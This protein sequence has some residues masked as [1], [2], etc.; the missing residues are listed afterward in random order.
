[1]SDF[2]LLSFEK[3][4]AS[5]ELLSKA[6]VPCLHLCP[7]QYVPI[8][9][10][11]L[12]PQGAVLVVTS[13][14]SFKFY[15]YPEFWRHRRL[16][17]VGKGTEA[18]AQTLGLEPEFVGDAGGAEVVQAAQLAAPHIFHVGGSDLS[19]PLQVAL[20][21]VT[22]TRMPVYT[23]KENALFT[24]STVTISL[25]AI[26]SPAAAHAIGRHDVFSKAP[27]VCIGHTTAEA[28]TAA[29]LLVVGVAERPRF[30]DLTMLAISAY[31]HYL[32]RSS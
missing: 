32:H 10:T 12:P 27:C 20:E 6:E 4:T 8:D 15:P 17:V 5:L 3:A 26:A 24:N 19:E 9:L 29:G 30:V 2:L 14:R 18:A 21:K 7:Y 22:H 16:F 25:S 11:V 23:R 28:A 31:N 1:M 13:A